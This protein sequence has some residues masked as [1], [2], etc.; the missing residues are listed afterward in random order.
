MKNGVHKGPVARG[1]QILAYALSVPDGGV[2]SLARKVN[3]QP[4]GS[5][6]WLR[7]V[8]FLRSHMYDKGLTL[9]G[10]LW[11]TPLPVP[12]APAASGRRQAVGADGGVG[13]ATAA[14]STVKTLLI[15]AT[16]GAA[17]W[18]FWRYGMRDDGSARSATRAYQRAPGILGGRRG[19]TE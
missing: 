13:G 12:L 5:A 2:T 9:D 7:G 6:P 16:A 17:I 14:T 1:K 4:I 3:E 10:D 15:V 8:E 11:Q 18:L 19:Y